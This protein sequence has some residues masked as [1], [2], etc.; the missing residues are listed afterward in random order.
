[1]NWLA[2]LLL[3][4]SSI[5]YQFGNLLADPLKGKAWPDASEQL[6]AGI[7]MHK[8]IDSFTD[9]HPLFRQSKG[10]FEGRR[11]LNGVVVDLVYDHLLTKHWPLYALLSLDEFIELF[12]CRAL[13]HLHRLPQK[14]A[15]F[16]QRL[17]HYQILNSYQ[18]FDGVE[19]ALERIDYRI[20][21]RLAA[22]E[23]AISYLPLV[24]AH[25][26]ALEEDFLAFFPELIAFFKEQESMGEGW[27]K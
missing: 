21:P 12:H 23:T 20:S 8:R 11:Y 5:D 26:E 22:K 17:V 27:I 18:S 9:A 14:P 15:D 4:P 10:R 3:S 13:K 7:A 6:L 24:A 1:M 25:L 19:R 16:V 2:H